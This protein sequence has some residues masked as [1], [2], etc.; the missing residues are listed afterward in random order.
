MG[1]WLRGLAVP[2]FSLWNVNN[3]LG[4]TIVDINTTLEDP[5]FW[6]EY[7][8]WLRNGAPYDHQKDE[9]LMAKLENSQLPLKYEL[10]GLSFGLD[11]TIEPMA[12]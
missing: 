6:T 2:N 11:P 3:P 5:S 8:H 1:T 12:A 10:P 4:T 7:D 9:E